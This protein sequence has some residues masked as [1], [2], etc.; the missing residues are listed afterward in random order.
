MV[1][2]EEKILVLLVEKYRNSKKDTGENQIVRKTRIKPK[3]LYKNYNENDADIGQINAVNDAAQTCSQKGFVTFQM[4][5]FSNEIAS[6]CLVDE[7][8]EKAEQYLKENYGYE[9]KHEK[10]YYIEQMIKRY[11]KKSP[12]AEQECEKLRAELKKNRVPKNY[13]Q[14]EDVLKALIFIENNQQMLYLREASMLIYG[15]SKYLEENCLESVC[16]LLRAS[17][18]RPCTEEEQQDEIL[19]E[20][21]IEKERQ[22]LCLKG[23]ITVIRKGEKIPL[24]AFQNGIEF[25]ADEV[26]Q[27]EQIVVHTARLITVENKTSYLRAKAEDTSFFYLGG[28]AN[29]FQR[30]FLK[31]IYQ[32]NPTITYLHFGDIDAGGFYI[33]EHLCR[34]STIPFQMYQMSEAQLQDKRYG[35][36]LQPLTENDRKR[37][38][39]LLGQETYQK[40]VK[41]M[42]E[43]NVKLEQEIISYYGLEF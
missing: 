28:Y 19:S 18:K 43:H 3:D 24:G 7:K 33:H 6:I 21:G 14:T 23:K 30:D 4:N 38:T 10:Q 41:Y 20:Y 34:V 31:K 29:R 39:S 13:L 22:K 37:L 25:Y 17:K 36:C 32:D 26:E 9:T 42:L 27:I 5:G 8:V 1:N 11:E 16:R 15:N 12:T 35:T 2:Y 40:T